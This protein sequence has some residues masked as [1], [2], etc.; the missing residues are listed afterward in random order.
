MARPLWVA[1]AGRQAPRRTVQVHNAWTLLGSEVG[2]LDSGPAPSLNCCVVWGR[3]LRCVRLHLEHRAA[4][5]LA[6]ED[7]RDGAWCGLWST[8][9]VAQSQGRG[10]SSG[11]C[12]VVGSLGWFL[13]LLPKCNLPSEMCSPPLAWWIFHS[14]PSH[15]L[16]SS[17][18]R[19]RL[20]GSPPVP[21]CLHYPG[22]T[23]L[24]RGC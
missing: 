24:Q 7:S 22:V 17:Q 23:T 8:V 15:Q 13:S 10:P 11:L 1:E 5:A 19:E 2:C 18:E 9:A 16:V 12:W 21:C 14:A 6:T 4:L 3:Q 20:V